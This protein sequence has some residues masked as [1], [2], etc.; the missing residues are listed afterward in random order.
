MQAL[1]KARTAAAAQRKPGSRQR[2]ATPLSRECRRVDANAFPEDESQAFLPDRFRFFKD[3]V[4]KRFRVRRPLFGCKSRSWP[5]MGGPAALA[6]IV[7]WAW[8]MH[9]R[10]VGQAT[11]VLPAHAAWAEALPDAIP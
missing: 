4:N 8:R 9:A 6:R 3:T 7:R 1:A 10:E 5:T 11:F 2:R